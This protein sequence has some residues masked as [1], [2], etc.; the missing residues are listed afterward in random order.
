MD[1]RQLLDHLNEALTQAEMIPDPPNKNSKRDWLTAN[2]KEWTIRYITRAI[3]ELEKVTRES[4]ELMDEI[5]QALAEKSRLQDYL[6]ATLF[7]H[8]K[9]NKRWL[10]WQEE[11]QRWVVKWET[12]DA[13]GSNRITVLIKT[14]D[15]D[16]AVQELFS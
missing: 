3:A 12:T 5:S 13:E 7:A 15:F 2:Q 6:K 4:V 14:E 1:T 11:T 16:E 9:H 8:I 10:V